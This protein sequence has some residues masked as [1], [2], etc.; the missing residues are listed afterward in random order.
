MSIELNPKPEHNQYTLWKAANLET[1]NPT[2]SSKWAD[3]LMNRV[4]VLRYTETTS[5]QTPYPACLGL[6]QLTAIEKGTAIVKLHRRLAPEL[7]YLRSKA[8]HPA[9]LTN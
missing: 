8:E 2:C 6:P 5:P 1:L 9:L 7:G 4:S 3:L